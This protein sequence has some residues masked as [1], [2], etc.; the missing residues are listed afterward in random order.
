MLYYVIQF[1]IFLELKNKKA[2]DITIKRARHVIKE[3]QRTLEAAICLENNN[4]TRFG[5][6]MN[7][8]HDSLRN[9]YEVSSEELDSL[10]NIARNVKGVMGSR[11]TGAGFGGCTITLVTKDAV[12]D[13]ITTIQEKFVFINIFNIHIFS[14]K[15]TL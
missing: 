3:I 5:E 10:V 7:E 1:F 4:F 13:L 8:S 2:S 14:N 12:D 15:F 6:L 9:D 11:L